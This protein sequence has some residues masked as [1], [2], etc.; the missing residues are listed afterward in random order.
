MGRLM[1]GVGGSLLLA[2]TLSS[3]VTSQD[4]AT[5]LDAGVQT[6]LDR[7]RGTWRD[8]NVPESDG[9]VLHNLISISC[10]R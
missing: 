3:N 4:R 8:L 7:H 5:K 2:A 6:F 9:R 1:L 10:K